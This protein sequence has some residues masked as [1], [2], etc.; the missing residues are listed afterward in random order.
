[1]PLALGEP[2]DGD[3]CDSR[4]SVPLRLRR[5][6]NPAERRPGFRASGRSEPA[7]DAE[8]VRRHDEHRGHQ[9]G[10]ELGGHKLGVL[11]RPAEH[12]GVVGEVLL[13]GDER[14]L[15]RVATLFRR[16]QEAEQVELDRLRRPVRERGV[17]PLGLEVM[18]RRVAVRARDA[19]PD[20]G[21]EQRDDEAARY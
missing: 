10:A 6:L 1:M 11:L 15:D 17:E 19:R 20:K 16:L 3:H 2:A 9:A 8:A 4:E 21:D 14:D 18:A 13:G 12:P 5:R 7:R